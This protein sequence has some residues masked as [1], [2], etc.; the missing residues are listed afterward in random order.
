MFR[1]IILLLLSA[2]LVSGQSLPGVID[3]HAHADPDGMARSIDAFEL[4]R[5]AKAAGMRGFV[6]KNH[7]ESTAGLAWLVRQQVPGI[8]VFGGIALNLP[9]GG[10]NPA[11]VEW[12]LKV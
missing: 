11:A 12:M 1:S 9:V 3:I 2:A 4:A 6:L 10:I 5:Q 7:Y 8:E